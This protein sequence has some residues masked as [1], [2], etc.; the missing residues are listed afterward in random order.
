[1]RA[2][3]YTRVS[4]SEQTADNQLLQL[5]EFAGGRGHEIVAE[6]SE[7]V[8]GGR[9][10]R[11]ELARMLADAARGRFELLLFWSLDRLSRRGVLHTLEI[12]QRLQAAGVKFRSLQ[13]PELDTTGPWGYVIVALFATLAQ[14]ERDLLKER[15][16]A[17]MARARAAGH[18]IGRPRR[19][20]NIDTIREL[21]AQGISNVAAAAA[22]GISPATLKRRL[23][24]ELA[25]FNGVSSRPAASS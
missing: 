9:A 6:Y 23:A 11:P 18:Q 7:Q 14:V 8:S 24:A 2:A 5:R 1:M 25:R 15:T 4:T 10:E 13:Q 21:K 16:R 12:L 17:G 22:V 20:A 3:I 19:V